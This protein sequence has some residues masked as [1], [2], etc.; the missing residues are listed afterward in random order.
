MMVLSCVY[1]LTYVYIFETRTN[2]VYVIEEN[3]PNK[4][5]I[6]SFLYIFGVDENDEK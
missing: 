2:V 6:C 3:D 1:P 4:L 5:I